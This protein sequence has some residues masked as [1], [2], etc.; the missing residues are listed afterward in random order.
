MVWA[1]LFGRLSKSSTWVDS[2]YV[3]FQN[4]GGADR[5]PF[6]ICETPKSA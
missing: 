6:R 4:S 3:A 5:A 2:L 1:N